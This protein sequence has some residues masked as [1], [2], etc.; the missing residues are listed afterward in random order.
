M[1]ADVAPS[2]GGW[3]EL[4]GGGGAAATTAT[5]TA[6]AA[7]SALP[8][9]STS[10]LSSTSASLPSLLRALD[11]AACCAICRDFLDAPMVLECGHACE[12]KGR[13]KAVFAFLERGDCRGLDG[14]DPRRTRKT[15]SPL[16]PQQQTKKPRPLSQTV[17][18]ACIR[19]NL[20]F[21]AREGTRKAAAP[22]EGA[23]GEGGGALLLESGSTVVG[24]CYCPGCREPADARALR[25][26]PLALRSIV[27]ALREK[28]DG[29]VFFAHD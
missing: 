12:F 27:A 18:S 15:N 26:A 24:G 2:P 25:R 22:G 23:G 21:Q 4:P 9:A 7:A 20:E 16:L 8:P 10:L 19:S 1:D 17:C 5:A 29:F 13:L 6:T 28:R 11:D 14:I 3:E